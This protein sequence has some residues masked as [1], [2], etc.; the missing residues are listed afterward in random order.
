MPN[1]HVDQVVNMQ[2]LGATFQNFAG[3]FTQT[4]MQPQQPKPAPETKVPVVEQAD[5]KMPDLKMP[6]QPKPQMSTQPVG[7]VDD[8]YVL[9]DISIVEDMTK[10]DEPV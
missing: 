1:M 5:L 7:R 4:M 8:E 6:E 2:D 3:L 9:E 10:D